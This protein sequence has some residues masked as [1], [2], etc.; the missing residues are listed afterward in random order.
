MPLARASGTRSFPT[1]SSR[2][3]S[4]PSP[5]ASRPLAAE[6]RLIAGETEIHSRD[7]VV[8]RHLELDVHRARGRA[9]KNRPPEIGGVPE[10]ERSMPLS[11]RKLEMP[12]LE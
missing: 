5:S 12:L 2:A 7:P 1:L 3:A 11:A 10:L 6:Q 8:G 9:R 4:P